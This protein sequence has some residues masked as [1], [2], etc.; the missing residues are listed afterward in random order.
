M[1]SAAPKAFLYSH[2]IFIQKLSTDWL[3]YKRK[4]KPASPSYNRI[5]I[6]LFG[7]FN[8]ETREPPRPREASTQSKFPAIDFLKFL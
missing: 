6:T 1:G 3:S 2:E 4:K 7:E 8:I 5:N